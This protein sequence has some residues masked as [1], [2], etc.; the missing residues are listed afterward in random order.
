I[1]DAFDR[2]TE[3]GAWTNAPTQFRV[4][5]SSHSGGSFTIGRM[6]KGWTGYQLPA[7]LKTLILF[8]GLHRNPDDP[9][10]K[11]RYDQIDDFGTWIEGMLTGHLAVLNDTTLTPAEKQARLDA[12]TQV[13]LY[14]DPNGT[15]AKKYVLL[16]GRIDRWFERNKDAIDTNFQ[17]L[18]DLVIMVPQ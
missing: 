9:D 4:V 18:R 1:R 5:L 8:E 17:V 14:W 7:N 6:I 15:Y 13:R 16:V 3:L 2:L 11:K 12:A 10:P